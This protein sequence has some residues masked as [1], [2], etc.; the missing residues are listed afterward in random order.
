M[1]AGLIISDL[2]APYHHPDSLDFLKA[3]KRKYS[4]NWVVCI[5]DELDNH[6]MSF[7]DSDPDL[8]AA[9]DELKKGREFLWELEKVF[10]VVDLVDSNHGSMHYRK[11]KAH[12][13]PRHLL[14]GYKDVIFGEHLPD[15]TITRK[16]GDGWNWFPHAKHLRR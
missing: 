15:G 6:A 12:G 16:R 2:H 14:L 11:G 1:D 8:N 9:G 7:H 4:F 10:P 5:G 3:L 13:F